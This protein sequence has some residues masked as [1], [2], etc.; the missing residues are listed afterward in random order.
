MLLFDGP[1]RWYWQTVED[2]RFE[3]QGGRLFLVGTIPPNDATGGTGEGQTVATAWEHV[4]R[5]V[6]YESRE[7]MAAE[8]RQS[9]RAW[10]WWRRLVG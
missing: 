10:S 7:A 9:K 8:R 4:Q 6:V 5:Y 1:E 3:T 2:A